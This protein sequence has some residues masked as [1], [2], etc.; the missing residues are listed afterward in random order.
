MNPAPSPK[1]PR[2]PRPKSP[3]SLLS[4]AACG[5]VLFAASS[6]AATQTWSNGSSDGLWN[7]TSLNWDAGTA[8]VQSNDAVFNATGVGAVNVSEPI[9]ANSLTFNSSGYVLSGNTLSVG[10][11]NITVNNASS[12]EIQNPLSTGGGFFQFVSN[13]GSTLTLSGGGTFADTMFF[14]GDG[15]SVIGGGATYNASAI[16]LG[17]GGP[18][19]TQKASTIELLYSVELG[20]AGHAQYTMDDSAALLETAY[21]SLILGSSAHNDG[22]FTLNDGTLNIGKFQSNIIASEIRVA[23]NGGG[24]GTNTVTGTYNQNG[25]RATAAGALRLVSDMKNYEIANVNIAG[26]VLTVNSIQF[27]NDTNGGSGNDGTL[28]TSA[29]LNVTGGSIYV[30]PGGIAKAVFA[31]VSNAINLS[32]GTIGATADWSSSMDM[33][34]GTTNG[35]IKIKA[36]DESGVAHNIALSGILSGTGG[37]TKIGGGTLTLTG[38]NTYQGPTVASEGILAT[39]ATGTF[40]TGSLT[41]AAGATVTIGNFTSISDTG[42]LIFDS[43]STI[44]LSFTGTEVIGSLLDSTTNTYIAPAT[45]TTAQLNDFFGVTTFTGS[46]SLQVTAVPE[47]AAWGLMGLGLAFVSAQARFRRR[48]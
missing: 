10:A 1:S 5:L 39:G 24:D 18:S 28:G 19:V 25:G 31:P 32:G 46:G 45:Y 16:K 3:A 22:T 12:V 7:T 34:L 27:G 14:A 48:K 41:V 21:E 26:G 47:P 2:F 4:G 15:Q 40:G 6:H 35:N 20:Y 11:G 29:T 44:N 13:A 17:F 43:G 38:A 9:S 30:G 33:A 23:F 37:L 8:W 36:A 42:D